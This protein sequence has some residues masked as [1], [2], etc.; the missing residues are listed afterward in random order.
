M[1]AADRPLFSS[2]YFPPVDMFLEMI[3]YDQIVIEAKEHF[4]KQSWRNR[5]HIAG[6]N[7]LQRLIVPLRH[8]DLSH[9]PMDEVLISYEENWPTTHRRSFISA[10][11]NSP[12]FDYFEKDFFELTEKRFERLIDLNLATIEFLYLSFRKKLSFELTTSFSPAVVNDHRELF[13]PKKQAISNLKYRQV[14]E[15]K[16]GFIS[17]VSALDL[18]FNTA[19]LD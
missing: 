3:R 17:Q 7:G 1:N 4:I 9:T 13:H 2:A 6:A 16:N 19:T 12:F 15:E 5:C 8:N 14:F 11:S 18:L 10:Y